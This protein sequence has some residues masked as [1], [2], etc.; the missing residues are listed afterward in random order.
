LV[1]IINNNKVVGHEGRHRAIVSK[2]QGVK[3]VPVLVIPRDYPRVPEWSADQHRTID[4]SEFR[5]EQ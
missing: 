4:A 3:L 5:A 2:Q 1:L